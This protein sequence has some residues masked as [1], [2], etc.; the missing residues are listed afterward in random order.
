MIRESNVEFFSTR[1]PLSTA[2]LEAQSAS[3]MLGASENGGLLRKGH[4]PINIFSL[5]IEIVSLCLPVKDLSENDSKK[6]RKENQTL[7][8][9]ALEPSCKVGSQENF[10]ANVL[11]QFVVADTASLVG[12]ES[13]KSLQLLQGLKGTHLVI[14]KMGK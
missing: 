10:T 6:V 4:E 11:T 13:R 1:T 7:E 9:D 14:T 12:K 2:R 5:G 8:L 3:E